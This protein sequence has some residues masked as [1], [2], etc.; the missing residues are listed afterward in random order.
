MKTNV[1]DVLGGESVLTLS[2]AERADLTELASSLAADGSREVDD[3]NWLA[4]ARELCCQLPPRLA[5]S[6]RRFTWDSGPE[7]FLLLRGLPVDETTLPPTPT[8]AGSVQRE[9][10]VPASALVL[11]AMAMGEL[12][13]FDK[14]KAGALVQDV[15]P[16]HGMEEFQGNAGSV[17]LSMHVENAFHEHRPDYVGLMCLRNDHDRVAGLRLS[18]VRNA[19]PLLSDEVRS[20][21]HEPRYV[22]AAPPSFDLPPGADEPHGILTGSPEDPSIKVDFHATVPGDEVA[23]AAMSSLRKALDSVCRTLTLEPGDLAFADNRLVLHGRTAFEPRYDGA[24]RWLQRV[25]VH[26]DF[27][28]SRP[29]RRGGGHVITGTDR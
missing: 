4:T 3:P 7:A 6:L 5:S 11:V 25:F 9:A 2:D 16:V 26:L 29:L 13:A 21:L 23:A 28:R 24:D 14:E 27:R 19:L 17:V 10:S 20:V 15:V 8:V 22:T 12:V 1:T 18:S